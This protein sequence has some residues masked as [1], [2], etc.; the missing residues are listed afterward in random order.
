MKSAVENPQLYLNEIFEFHFLNAIVSGGLKLCMYISQVS[1]GIDGLKSNISSTSLPGW[2]VGWNITDIY[3]PCSFEGS[4]E[5]LTTE[6]LTVP[7]QRDV[8]YTSGS[9]LNGPRTITL[10]ACFE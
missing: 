5:Q 6:A 7:V 3:H 1:I 10:R 4:P 2:P 8:C 9:Y